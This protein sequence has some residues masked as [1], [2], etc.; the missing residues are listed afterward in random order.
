MPRRR[1]A[2]VMFD[3]IHMATGSVNHL[4][5]LPAGM[6]AAELPDA[7]ASDPF[8][9]DFGKPVRESA[10]ECER[11]TGMVLGPIMKLINGP[12]VANAIADPASELNQLVATEKD[13]SKLIQE[14]F[15]RFL[16][17]NPTEQEI[18]LSTEAL[19]GSAAEPVV[20]LSVGAFTGGGPKLRCSPSSSGGRICDGF[21][22]SFD[23]TALD[24]RL[25]IPSGAG[26]FPLVA[27]IHGYAGSKT[28]SEDIASRLLGDGYAI[29]R[30]ST[31]G[32]GKSW[33]Q[34]NLA[35]RIEMAGAGA[36]QSFPASRSGGRR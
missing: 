4:P 24:V 26:P 34:V 17:R 33:G 27:L 19:K 36:G 22:R 8:L 35:D 32:F 2:E 23:K 1:P 10:C 30:Y 6:R 9:D 18:K 21:L 29:L 7:G 31:R 13:D 12:T 15:L 5:G 11:S 16:A 20:V 25:E 28:S 3:A 14:V